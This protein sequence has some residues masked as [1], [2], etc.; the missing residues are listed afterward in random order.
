MNGDKVS[1]VECVRKSAQPLDRISAELVPRPYGR[2]QRDWVESPGFLK[3]AGYGVVVAQDGENVA[4]GHDC[5]ALIRVG[6]I[7]HHVAQAHSRIH[8]HPIDAGQYRL[9]CVNIGVKVGNYGVTQRHLRLGDT[10][11]VMPP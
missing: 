11:P 7:A 6:V 5:N 9:Q 2:R 4:L 3:T 1:E 8:P 10:V